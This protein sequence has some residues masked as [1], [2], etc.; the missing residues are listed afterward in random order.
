MMVTQ[1]IIIESSLRIMACYS[2]IHKDTKRHLQN[3]DAQTLSKDIN[4]Q[5]ILEFLGPL[6]TMVLQKSA[7][8][9]AQRPNIFKSI[10]S[11]KLVQYY[12]TSSHKIS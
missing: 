6:F 3:E 4:R 2:V 12:P 11:P 10:E 5:V 1:H 7:L 8:I 9:L